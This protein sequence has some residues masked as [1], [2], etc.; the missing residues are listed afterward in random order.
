[1]SSI[2]LV[3]CTPLRSYCTDRWYKLKILIL[4]RME[5]I[6]IFVDVGRSGMRRDSR[7]VEQNIYTISPMGQ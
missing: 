4:M 5:K 1:M 2:I 6:L 7:D 3:T